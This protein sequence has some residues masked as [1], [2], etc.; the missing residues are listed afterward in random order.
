MNTAQ[1]DP[2]GDDNRAYDLGAWLSACGWTEEARAQARTGF[3][4]GWD[5]AAAHDLG[6]PAPPAH[7]AYEQGSEETGGH[8]GNGFDEGRMA[9]ESGDYP[10]GITN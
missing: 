1:P 7:I 6:L 10:G 3:H 9:Y 4:A 8:F 2:D 5:W